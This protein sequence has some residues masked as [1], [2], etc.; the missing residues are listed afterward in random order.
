[1]HVKTTAPPSP[2]RR[3]ALQQIGALGAALS[4]GLLPTAPRA[5]SQREAKLLA[6]GLESPWGMA[7]L[8][9][10]RLLVTER[11]GRLRV[12]EPGGRVAAAVAGVPAV[13]HRG[14]G[15]LMDVEADPRFASN[16]LI[17]LS[18]TEA[19]SGAEQGTNCIAVA[20][21]RLREDA[22]A[23]EEMQV[24]LRQCPRV[25]SDEHLGGRMAL[26]GGG[27]LFITIG[28]RRVPEER[29]KAQDLSTHHGKVLRIRTD[30]SIPADNP[31]LAV[32]DALPEI[33]SYGHRNPQGACLHP[34]TGELWTCEH[35]P[36][37]GDEVNIARRGRNY[38]WPVV[39]HGCEYD[40]CAPIGEGTAKQGMEDPLIW[41]PPPNIAPSSVLIYSGQRHPEWQGNLFVGALAGQ[42][43]WR[44]E[45][46]G[47]AAAPVVGRREALLAGLQA[48]IRDVK[49]GPD[50][51]I[52]VLTDG[53]GRVLRVEP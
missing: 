38:G 44:I 8:P 16:R 20:R 4:L 28:D 5:A 31:F 50:G 26:S 22:A 36:L 39:S 52:Y 49:Q 45:L 43:L 40:T 42:A 34:Q 14:H 51:G 24:I 21:G 37:G 41:W 15:G 6:A 25:A 13:D 48:R 27:L 11:P 17:Y 35:G 47:S 18:Y 33:W 23:L 46:G 32:P 9:D 10:G 53:E 29:V 30:G 19:G 12:V 2:P 3:R 1:M 7:F